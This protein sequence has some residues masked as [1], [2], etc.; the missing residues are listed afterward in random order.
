MDSLFAPGAADF[1]LN[2]ALKGLLGMSSLLFLWFVRTLPKIKSATDTFPAQVAE[3]TSG[4]RSLEASLTSKLDTLR[5]EF[6]KE[7]GQVRDELRAADKSLQSLAKDHAVRDARDQ[8]I[9]RRVSNVET[10]VDGIIERRG[11]TV[12]P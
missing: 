4:L 2:L 1:L 12:A 9:E 8:G 3:L 10:R 6:E 7:I 5:S 11:P